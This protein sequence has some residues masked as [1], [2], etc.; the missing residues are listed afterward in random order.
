MKARIASPKSKT[1]KPVP[2]DTKCNGRKSAGGLCQKPA[3]WGTNHVGQGRCRRH[4]GAK[5][6]SVSSGLYSQ[7]EHHRIRDVLNR[8]DDNEI[9][10]LDLAPEAKL[11]RAM[12]IDYI[13]RYSQFSEELSAWYA[14]PENKQRPRRIMDIQDAGHLVESI[15]RIVQ[16]MHQIQSTGAISLETFKRV[17]EHMGIIVAKHVTDL[18]TLSKIEKEWMDLALDTKAPPTTPSSEE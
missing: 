13:N 5:T 18:V 14:D 3:G 15:S 6:K 1:I 17:S 4:G 7:I 10:V 9:N 12:V 2:S 8:M 11:L 16:R